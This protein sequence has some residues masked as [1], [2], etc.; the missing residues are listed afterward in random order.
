MSENPIPKLVQA[1]QQV[2]EL[3]IHPLLDELES[4]GIGHSLESS[5]LMNQAIAD[6]T[7]K[8][9]SL[10]ERQGMERDSS[11]QWQKP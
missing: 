5:R 4:V 3:K 2:V 6:F 7:R 8:L 9:N 1:L 10:A 11:G